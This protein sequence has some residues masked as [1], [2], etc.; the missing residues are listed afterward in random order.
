MS[1]DPIMTMPGAFTPSGLSGGEGESQE[2]EIAYQETENENMAKSLNKH[3]LI[4]KTR[5]Q[6]EIIVQLDRLVYLIVGFQL[7][8][9]CHMACILPAVGHVFVQMLLGYGSLVNETDNISSVQV[10]NETISDF[11]RNR[12]N[13]EET[14]NDNQEPPSREEIIDMIYTRICSSIY[15]KSLLSCIYHVIFMCLWVVPMSYANRVHLLLYNSWWLVSFIGEMVPED[16]NESTTYWQRLVKL[17]MPGLLL[18]DI[19]ITLIQ[20]ILFQCIYNQS[21]FSTR[22][23]NTGQ[24]EIYLVRGFN[25]LPSM[26]DNVKP[27]GQESSLVLV[28]KLFEVFKRLTYSPS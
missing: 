13:I 26:P 11:V 25:N 24:Q 3:Y 21:T 1:Y 22:G 14:A 12:R 2:D 18:S 20:V 28:V 10:I 15:W 19:F 6:R 8:K 7:L 4:E 27:E 23:Q 17:G 9:Y 16:I 5:G